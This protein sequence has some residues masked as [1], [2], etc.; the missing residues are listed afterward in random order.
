MKFYKF[1][2]TITL[3]KPEFDKIINNFCQDHLVERLSMEIEFIRFRIKYIIKNNL[4][5]NL[6]EDL[7]KK[8]IQKSTE[9]RLTFGLFLQYFLDTVIDFE[10]KF[11]SNNIEDILTDDIKIDGSFI[12]FK[13]VVI[14]KNLEYLEFLEKTFT[15]E[16]PF[17]VFNSFFR[18]S[19]ESY[20]DAVAKAF[21]ELFIE[22]EQNQIGCGNDRTVFVHS[23]TFQTSERCSLRCTY[24]YQFNKT[25]MRMNFAT[26]K[27]FIDNL[28]IDK[29]SYINKFNSPA[30]ILEF[31]G[32][33]PLLEINL[34]R[35]IYE[36]FLKRCYELNHPWFDFHRVS[37][38]SN[39]LQYFDQDVQD[40]FKDYSE[41]ISFNVSIDG[42]K[43]LHDMCRIQPNGEGSYD[44]AMAALKHYTENY[45]NERNSKMTLAPSNIKY[46]FES[47]SDFIK[48]GMTVINL[49][50]V[51]EEGWNQET[52]RTEYFQLKRL[53]D[54][55]VTNNL[56]NIYISIFGERQEDIHEKS[57]DGNFCGGLGSMLALR[58]NGDFYPC[59]RY[60]PTSVGSNVE[61]LNLGSVETGL[62]GREEGSKVLQMMDRIT[63][64]SQTNDICFNCPIG[65]D[66]ANCSALGHTVFGTPEKRTTFTCIQM[67]AEALAN[68][69]YWNILNIKHPEYELGVRK[70]NVPE[71]WAKLVLSEEE[72][73]TLHLLEI[74]SMM[75]TLE[76]KTKENKNG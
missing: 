22:K 32:G 31:I 3:F 25:N 59:I 66:C 46:L 49:N 18:Y 55:L 17:R 52:A 65:N 37:I 58:P 20:N 15:S 40:F 2:K 1:E 39:G 30:I 16:E 73:E 47:V 14:S 63:R 51:F 75:Q 4:D 53:A 60:M 43:M 38:C 71:E 70:N 12:K 44:I 74:S 34:T 24:C 11:P 19:S 50:C 72:L 28:L 62:V 8:F 54:Y 26:A 48:N 7:K 33:E 29:Y 64:R 9:L 10:K 5:L 6:L 45:V 61:D 35:K 68:V 76:Y 36:Y 67:I 56:E 57:Y 21:P 13:V 69:Y 23:F 27:K 42:S 41:N